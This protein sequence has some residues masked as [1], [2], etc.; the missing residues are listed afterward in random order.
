MAQP[1]PGWTQ[2]H[3]GVWE[4]FFDTG[5]L[6]AQRL[7]VRALTQPALTDYYLNPR[8]APGC[9]YS[10]PTPECS[11]LFQDE[12]RPILSLP[13]EVSL[14]QGEWKDC[15]PAVYGVYDPPKPLLHGTTADGPN[16]HPVTVSSNKEKPT[17]S[18][19]E[20]VP[21]SGLTTPIPTETSDPSSPTSPS[22]SDSSTEMSSE[23]IPH[24][25]PA[26]PSPDPA[27]H[28]SVLGETSRV[29][30][31]LTLPASISS[32]D[33]ASALPSDTPGSMESTDRTIA[34]QPPKPTTNALSV[35]E[36]AATESA[37]STV[38][39]PRPASVEMRPGV[40]DPSETSQLATTT[41]T[42]N[43]GVHTTIND[44]T[45]SIGTSHAVVPGSTPAVL[46]SDP[47]KTTLAVL[48]IP[49]LV[50]AHAPAL[51]LDGSTIVAGSAGVVVGGTT[52]SLPPSGSGVYVNGVSSSLAPAVP[53]SDVM[54]GSITATPT[55]ISNV[56]VGGA[57]LQ[58]G[59][60]TTISGTTY[61]LPSSGSVV[62][63]NGVLTSLD[64]GDPGGPTPGLPLTND[65]TIE[66]TLD[67]SMYTLWRTT[68]SG[69][70]A[71][72]VASQTLLQGSAT[73]VSDH[74]FS[75]VPSGIIVDGTTP[76]AS[77]PTGSNV[78]ITLDGSV[79]TLTPTLVQGTQALVLGASTLLAGSEL[80]VAGE[81]LS[82]G[83][84]GLVLDGT[85]TIPL[86]ST[87][88][89]ATATSRESAGTA[90]SSSDGSSLGGSPTSTETTLSG[91]ARERAG[92][93][94]AVAICLAIG[95]VL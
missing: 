26:V 12:Y 68:L 59:S 80:T 52:L 27:E 9:E 53:G 83:P 85:R 40:P 92:V 61:S 32:L 38:A 43:S 36:S 84:T 95:A 34:A 2:W 29:K 77:A 94:L 58:P 51:L 18:T 11:T 71:L 63:V 50:E 15:A 66:V 73:V 56:V 60:D 48:N 88:A 49:S 82:L 46:L 16:T 45:V 31:D 86:A 10:Y 91:G 39:V 79:Y 42:L 81:T 44:G 14:L 19:I 64:G 62:Y 75:L 35:L 93:F 22:T 4:G 70:P 33:R 6:K 74:T 17:T 76:H 67:G 24:I 89:T 30:S 55:I 69:T 23:G 1:T 65:N 21:A 20:A 37:I 25:S 47:S 87:P 8:S 3:T 28:I 7:D 5:Q 13:A 90:S 57:A 78:V 41:A 72:V 54:I